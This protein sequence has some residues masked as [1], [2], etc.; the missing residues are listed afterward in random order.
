MDKTPR[1][2]ILLAAYGATAESSRRA[3][4]SFTEAVRSAHPGHAV[5]WAFTARNPLRRLSLNGEPGSTVEDALSL[6]AGEGHARIAVQPLHL[7]G[8]YEHESLCGQVAA[9]QENHPG[10]A[11]SVG[12]PLLQDTK[13][14]RKVLTVMRE[15]EER[16]LKPGETAVWV[17][18]GSEM[19]HYDAYRCLAEMGDA[20]TPPLRIG[21]LSGGRSVEECIPL[22]AGAGETTVCLVPFFALAGNHAAHDLGGGS[23]D[24]WQS[25]MREAGFTCRMHPSGMLENKTFAAMWL[26]R[27]ES[28]LQTV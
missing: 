25:R 20:T 22:L 5:R 19:P 23:P 16:L 18:H 21:F 3:L 10:A 15:T 24:S 11:V 8:G 13:A 9:W 1:P 27:L 2:G 17:A 14:I 6:L 7:V 28:V 4:L 26:D 12:E